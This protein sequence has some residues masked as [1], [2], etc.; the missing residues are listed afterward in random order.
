MRLHI[1]AAVLCIASLW[2]TQCNGLEQSFENVEISQSIDITGSYVRRAHEITV[3]N[4]ANS[5]QTDYY[6]AMEKDLA[7]KVSII[8]A[9]D[10]GSGMGLPIGEVTS[11]N[12]HDLVYYKVRFQ[13]PLEPQAI[14]R[15]LVAEAF[16]NVLSPLPELASQDD[17]QF[18]VYTTSQYPLSPYKTRSSTIRVKTLGTTVEQLDVA[19]NE[20]AAIN[21]SELV[22]GPHSDVEPFVRKPITIRYENPRPLVKATKLVRDIWVSH[23]G[24]S[25]SF[26]EKYW[27]KNIGTKLRSTF[28]RLDYARPQSSYSLNVA[29][30]KELNIPLAPNARDAYFVDLVGNVSTSHFHAN[31]KSSMLSV[32]P[33]Y[34]IFGGWSYNFSVGWSHDLKDYVRKIDEDQYIL[35]VPVLQGPPDMGYDKVYVNVIL[36]EGAADIKIVSLFGTD[37][38]LSKTYSYLDTIG[39]PTVKLAYGNLIDGHRGGDLY[40]QYTYTQWDALRKPLV[41]TATLASIFTMVLFLSKVDVSILKK[42]DY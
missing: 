33:R 25:I 27:L 14:A 23:W 8:E 3:K 26:E 41:I 30:L 39:R 5:P 36:P 16:T 10:R 15:I 21:G 2:A 32:K 37:L 9:Q 22:Y 42:R 19:D 40:V 38:S 1:G 13:P 28:S 35:K 4:V 6:F 17:H 20:K 11:D 24:S 12:E 29:A 18:M 34:P 7:P 31:D